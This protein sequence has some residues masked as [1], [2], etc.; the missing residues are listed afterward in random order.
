[1]D[2]LEILTRTK[3]ARKLESSASIQSQLNTAKLMES[4][5]REKLER[6]HRK[7]A[8]MP[9]NVHL[10][11]QLDD[12]VNSIKL[13]EAEIT[14]IP[15]RI[16]V[17]KLRLMES[18]ERESVK[19]KILKSYQKTQPISDLKKKSNLLL[20]RLKLAQ[21]TNSELLAMHKKRQQTEEATGKRINPGD[22]SGGFESLG[23]LLE[24]CEQENAGNG[25]KF[26]KWESIPFQKI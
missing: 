3:T 25:R 15:Y 17:L 19:R 2:R 4:E 11:R 16:D 14:D 12:L 18:R 13:T 22:V 21:Q 9:E 6:L 20:R 10:T 24:F 5:A 26:T 1:M 23:V 8:M 7:K